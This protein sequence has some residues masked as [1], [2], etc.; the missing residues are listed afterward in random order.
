M[1]LHR[2][3]GP[4]LA[5]ANE[6][7]D[8][9]LP[10]SG[11]NAFERNAIGPDTRDEEGPRGFKGLQGVRVEEGQLESI[12]ATEKS[13]VTH[14]MGSDGLGHAAPRITGASAEGQKTP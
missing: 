7:L 10:E 2:R 13:R 4:D 14:F 5:F 9:C 6:E 8:L 1:T 3:Q 12:D 11:V